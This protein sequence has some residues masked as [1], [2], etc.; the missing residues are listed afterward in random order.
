MGRHGFANAVPDDG[1]VVEFGR[2]I[3]KKTTKFGHGTVE[4]GFWIEKVAVG[5]V[6]QTAVGEAGANDIDHSV[7]FVGKISGGSA[8]RLEIV[9]AVASGFVG[10]FYGVDGVRGL[11]IDARDEA[12]KRAGFRGRFEIVRDF[13]R[14]N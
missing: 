12:G 13:E 10:V 14:R 9:G 11:R 2:D 3:G 8:N 4:I 7:L 6:E 5:K 1:D